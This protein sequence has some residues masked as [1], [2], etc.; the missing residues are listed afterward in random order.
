MTEKKA[1]KKAT[2]SGKSAAKKATGEAAV[3]REGCR[4]AGALPRDG[5][6][7]PRI[8]RPQRAGAPADRVVWHAGVRETAR[9][10]ASSARTRNT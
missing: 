4:D 9:P 3:P 7:H 10:S 6:A 1:K 2:E 8:D 5:R